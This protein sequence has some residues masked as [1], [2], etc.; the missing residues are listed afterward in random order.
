MDRNGTNMLDE[1]VLRQKGGDLRVHRHDKTIRV[2]AGRALYHTSRHLGPSGEPPARNLILP[3]GPAVRNLAKLLSAPQGAFVVLRL[4]YV[5]PALPIV[6]L[7][8][9]F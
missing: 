3:V 9:L 8:Q 6:D 4:D 1:H 5:F 2:I 7:T